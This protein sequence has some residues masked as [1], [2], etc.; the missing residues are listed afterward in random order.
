MFTLVGVFTKYRRKQR[1]ESAAQV[2]ELHV[3]ETQIEALK[4]SREV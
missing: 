3:I 1:C 4:D 2:L